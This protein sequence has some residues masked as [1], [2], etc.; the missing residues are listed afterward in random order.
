MCP[1]VLSNCS[2]DLPALIDCTLD[3]ELSLLSCFYKSKIISQ[4]YKNKLKSLSLSLSVCV[5]CVFTCVNMSLEDR[6]LPSCC[7]SALS[8]FFANL[9]Q[10]IPLTW[11]L[12]KRDNWTKN[13]LQVSTCDYLLSV[14]MASVFLHN[15]IFH[16]DFGNET[17]VLLLKRHKPH[18]FTNSLDLNILEYF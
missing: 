18:C 11:K 2:L 1:S 12:P 5:W 7:S 4:Q 14:C 3:C 6:K 17:Q 10:G 8:T 13:K 9:W 15:G 16:I